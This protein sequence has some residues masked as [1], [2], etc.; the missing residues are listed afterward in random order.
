MITEG[1]LTKF[2]NKVINE[3]LHLPHGTKSAKIVCHTDLDGVT[4]GITMVQQLIKQGIPKERITV[5]FAEYSDEDNDKNFKNRF[6]EDKKGQYVG[7]TDFAKLPKAKPSKIWNSLFDFKG[8]SK[9]LVS[10]FINNKKKYKDISQEEF[11]KK[12]ISFYGIKSNKFTNGNLKKLLEALKAYESLKEYAKKNKNFK[13]PIP[14]LEN[15]E[16]FSFPLVNPQFVSDHHSNDDGALSGGKTGEIATGSP[17]EAEFLAN[18]YANGMW[19]QEDLKAISAVDHADYTEEDLK[20]SIFM[21]KKFKGKDRHKNLATIISCVYDGLCKKDRSAA[22]WI[23]KNAKPSLVSLYTTTLKAAKYNGKRYD[24]V[25]A[26]KDGEIE[27]AKQLLSEIPGELNKRYDRRGDP[28]K[29]PATIEELRKKNKEDIANMKSGYQTRAD[30]AKLDEIKGKKDDASKAIRD[31]IKSKK[32]KISIYRNFAIFDGTSWKA[33]YSR[34][35][36]ALFSENGQRQPFGMRFWGDFFQISKSPFYKGVVDFSEVGKHVIEDVE[37]FLLDKDVNE[38]KVKS[39][40]DEMKEKN[41][42]HKGG[43]WTFSGFN[44]ITAPNK[45]TDDKYWKARSVLS[46]NKNSEIANKIMKEK[47][48]ELAKY[49]AIKKECMRKAM[50]SAIDWTNKLYPPSQEDMDKLK[51]NDKTFEHETK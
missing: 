11:D 28:T 44:K 1:I 37:K 39:V 42:G 26:L 29:K 40:I 23:V 6:I 51:T 45:V 32:G 36:N 25:E 48:P 2:R 3:E 50:S 31:E 35:S 33:N 47:E 46:K 10:L 8:D 12:M 17:S 34:Y 15:I 13:Y 7:V 20:N 49:A 21:V 16:S 41:G 5:E 14:T 27:K 38:F 4:S 19:S 22:A 43:I 18:K 30:K 24:Y 9:K